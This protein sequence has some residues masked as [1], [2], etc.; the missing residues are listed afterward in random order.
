[1]ENLKERLEKLFSQFYFDNK[2]SKFLFNVDEVKDSKNIEI[3]TKNVLNKEKLWDEVLLILAE[4]IVFTHNY[5]YI[6]DFQLLGGDV[7]NKYKLSDFIHISGKPKTGGNFLWVSE[8]DMGYVSFKNEKVVNVATKEIEYFHLLDKLKENV[9]SEIIKLEQ[10]KLE[11]QE[12]EKLK[13][14]ENLNN[15]KAAYINELD[16]DGNGIVDI[17]ES[18]DFMKLLKK[19]QKTILNSD[20]EHNESFTKKFVDVSTYLE[21]KKSNIQNIFN[22]LKEQEPNIKPSVTKEYYLSLNN[23]KLQQVKIVIEFTGLDLKEAKELVDSGND[24]NYLNF[25]SLSIEE[26]INIIRNQIHIYE[27]LPFPFTKYDQFHL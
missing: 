23:R 1:M 15:I 13:H 6:F 20:K 16:K 14:L 7:I 26:I 27:L 17:I 24:I 22:S 25:D 10:E 12:S 21:T 4:G 9:I 3:L 18:C 8:K 5:F 2:N 19:Y 11:Q